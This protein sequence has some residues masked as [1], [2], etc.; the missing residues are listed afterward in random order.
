MKGCQQQ[1]LNS[2]PSAEGNQFETCAD[3]KLRKRKMSPLWT[4]LFES[5]VRIDAKTWR[6]KKLQLPSK[7]I[8]SS[9]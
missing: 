3:L 1:Q 8:G 5:T 2:L 4:P 9:Y 7:K 6:V